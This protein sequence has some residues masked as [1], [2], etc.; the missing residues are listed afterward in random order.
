MLGYLT[1]GAHTICTQKE[2]GFSTY[3]LYD[4][5]SVLMGNDAVCKTVSIGSIR[6]RMFDGHVRTL[7]NVQI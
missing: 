4:G 5:G 1:R 6:M 7:T 3:K 2:S